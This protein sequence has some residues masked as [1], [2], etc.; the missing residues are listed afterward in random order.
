MN[1]LATFLELPTVPGLIQNDPTF[2]EEEI[3]KGIGKSY[4][5]STSLEKKAGKTTGH[6]NYAYTIS[7]RQFEDNNDSE[8]YPFR[9]THPHE[10]KI[11]VKHQITPSLAAFASWQYGSGQPFS[12]VTTTTRFSPLSNSSNGDEVRIGTING[13]RLPAY[14]RLDAGILFQWAGKNIQQ[15]LNLGVYNLYNR[16]NPYY[17]YLLED[18]FFVEDDGL[19]S[20]NALP[21]LPSIAYR[22]VF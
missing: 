4:G 9:F 17:Q 7:T 11:N 6:I 10:V 12:L 1:H 21:I 15:S 3:T 13:S 8:S 18:S 14:H 5:F 16:K 19:K 22:A 2:W 20:Q